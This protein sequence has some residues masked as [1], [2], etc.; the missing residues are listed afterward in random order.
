MT[1]QELHDAIDDVLDG[2]G[3]KEVIPALYKT[4]RVEYIVQDGKGH[5][6]VSERVT[7]KIRK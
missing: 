2:W 3:V 5:V 1:R 6:V 4:I 7:E